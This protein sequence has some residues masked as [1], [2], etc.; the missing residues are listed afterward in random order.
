MKQNRTGTCRT[1]FKEKSELLHLMLAGQFTCLG[2]QQVESKLRQTFR[3]SNLFLLWGGGSV[4][5]MKDEL[6]ELRHLRCS[7]NDSLHQK[8]LFVSVL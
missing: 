6:E 2:V 4:E 8:L 7:G 1:V 3:S 5:E